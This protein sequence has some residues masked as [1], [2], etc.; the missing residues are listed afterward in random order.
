MPYRTLGH[1]GE[2]VSAIG[3]GGWHLGLKTV[4]E[5][6][7]IR[8]IRSAVDRGINFMDNSWDYNDGASEKRMGRALKDGYRDRVLLMTKIDGRSKEAAAKQLDESLK[9]MGTDCIDL[10][11]HHE[12]IR[13]EDADRIFREG[14]ANEALLEAKE[15]GKLR[16]IGFTG[17]KDPHI[18]L[19][20][21]DVAREHG[22]T[23]DAVQMP[24]NVMDAHYRSFEKLVLPELVRRNVG[25]LGMKSLANGIILRSGTVTAAEC[26][27]YTLSLPTSVVITGCDSMEILDQA[28]AAATG[29]T[30]LADDERK[31]LLAK[32][33]H[34]A[35]SG[36]YEPFKTSS[37]FDS[38]ATNVEWLGEEPER[39]TSLMP[40]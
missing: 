35:R 9:R 36:E 17:H 14:G 25:V 31:A 27:R 12:V 33:A 21:L 38:T 18:H 3:L 1:T 28:I 23:F 20:T 15:A 39:L 26:L 37:I 2:R 8:I 11:Q 40:A 10:V 13:Y 19:H 30:P 29:F 16:Y 4:D 22:F 34:A 6:L 7:A 5:D 32:T 24:L